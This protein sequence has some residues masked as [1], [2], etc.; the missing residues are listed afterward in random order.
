MGTTKKARH[1]TSYRLTDEAQMM[2]KKLSENMGISH[3]SVLEVA[4]RDLARARSVSSNSENAGV[5]VGVPNAE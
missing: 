2:I 5:I 4:I 3:T 1:S